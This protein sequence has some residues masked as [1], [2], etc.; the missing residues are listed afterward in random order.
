MDC[1][2]I[3]IFVLY[4]LI[5]YC[6]LQSYLA[7]SLALCAN[8]KP[9][10]R[11][12]L[13]SAPLNTFCY[14]TDASCRTNRTFMKMLLMARL[15]PMRILYPHLTNLMKMILMIRTLGIGTGAL[16]ADHGHRVLSAK[17]I[18]EYLTGNL[19]LDGV[20]SNVRGLQ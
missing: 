4:N 6:I 12:F 5:L 17:T 14:T 7:Q 3:Y 13:S 20:L 10:G 9:L 2:H 19:V 16:Q 11:G 15:V 1:P 8:P 18:R